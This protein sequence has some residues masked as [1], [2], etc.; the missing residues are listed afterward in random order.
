MSAISK[1]SHSKSPW[2]D[3]VPNFWLKSLTSMHQDLADAFTNVIEH[4]EERPTWLT[5]GIS[6]LLPKLEG[7]GDPKNYRPVTC[8]LTM[9][10][11]LT[12]GI[13]E[14]T[15]RFLLE[16]QILSTEQKVC[17]HDSNSCEE[18]LLIN[19]MVIEDCKAWKNN[20]TTAWIDYK[21]A[22]DS[23]PHTWIIKCLELYKICLVA[24]NF[25]KECIKNWKTTLHLNHANSP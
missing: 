1:R 15:N 20:L 25:M 22:F 4:P 23:V 24:I 9:N 6:F 11:I 2:K 10:K 16:S 7:T 21:N 17:K 3:Q 13:T 8:L 18:Q 19:K 12:S 5:E 14:H